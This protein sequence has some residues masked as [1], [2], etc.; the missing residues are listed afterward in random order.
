MWK[1][2]RKNDSPLYMQIA[3]Y[4]EQQI[5]SGEFPPGSLLPSERK[6][7]EK[8][9][10]NRSTIVLAY[11]ELRALGLIESRP[12]SGTRV[13][14]TKWGTIP[15]QSIQWD[16]YL[17][18]ANAVSPKGLQKRVRDALQQDA[19][20]INLASGEL[21]SD[22]SPIDEINQFMK[23]QKYQEMLGYNDP[24]GSIKLRSAVANHLQSENQIQTSNASIL[25]TSGTQQALYLICHYLLSP[26]DTIAIEDPSFYYSMPMFEDAGLRVFRMKLEQTDQ[27]G[28]TSLSSDL[29]QALKK[30]RVK[31]IFL[32][33]N[34]QNP[35][36]AVMS[37]DQK[38]DLLLL[39]NDLGIPIVEVDPFSLTAFQSK[40]PQPLKSSDSIGS[41]I[42]IGSL[43]KTVA[44]GLRIGW[45]VA[46]R[47]IVEKLAEA[48]QLIDYGQSSLPQQ[49]AAEFISSEH[50]QAHLG[51]LRLHL[52]YKRDLLIEALQLHLS[53]LVTFEIPEGGLHLWC[54]LHF[55]VSETKL[56]DEAIKQ[57]V[58]FMPG[59][60]FGKETGHLRFTFARPDTD[61]IAI[62]VQRFAKAL[63][64][65][66]QTP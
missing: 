39:T 16:Q 26:G 64:T 59:S 14:S 5:I 60:V 56:L 25:I 35:T 20:L 6:L 21:N 38:L 27:Q 24:L 7:A 48:R 9:D 8:L 62:G 23:I 41:V 65:V 63:H 30:N 29:H 46:P 10:V 36:G 45:L 54:E 15:K 19:S 55:K 31:M 22:L 40:C 50:F 18:P 44:A 51:R 12:G 43:S 37:E 34:F 13:N 66:L 28:E 1:P 52:L 53:E 11:S 33:P 57:G 2:D 61:K 3:D 17:Q 4:I 49:V 47:L 32:N 42:Y 58:V